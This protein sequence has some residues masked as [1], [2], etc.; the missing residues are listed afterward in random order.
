M[1]AAGVDTSSMNF[2]G[3]MN[4]LSPEMIDA[5]AKAMSGQNNQQA[6]APPSGGDT[7]ASE[8]TG[9]AKSREL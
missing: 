6:N 8:D 2:G 9:A 5:L 1:K 7:G 4:N 3:G